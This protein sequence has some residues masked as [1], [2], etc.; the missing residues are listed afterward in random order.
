MDFYISDT[1]NQSLAKLNNDEQKLA[2]TT[3][4]DL[5]ANPA[6][7]GHSLHKLDNAKDK[8]FWSVRVGRDV[9]IIVHKS[10]SS[11]LLCYVDH[12]DKAYAWAQSRR[13]ETHPKTGAA[14]MV[15]IPEVVQASHEVAPKRTVRDS[16]AQDKTG[17]AT[18]PLDKVSD[19]VL[20][21]HGVPAD[22][23]APIRA[24]DEDGLLEICS[25]LPG[26]AAEALLQFAVGGKPRQL[27]LAL[28]VTTEV[29]SFAHPDAQRRFRLMNTPEALAL[30]LD[31]PW[32]RWVVFLHP[33]QRATVE[34][35]YAGPARVGG[36]AGTG[37]TIVALHRAVHLARKNPES[38]VLLTTFSTPLANALHDRLRRLVSSDRGLADRI[39]VLTLDALCDRLAKPLNAGT[40][41]SDATVKQLLT[42][43]A[44]GQ[45][46]KARPGFLFSEWS[47]VVDAWQ[48]VDWDSYRDARRLGRKT[49][50]NEERRGALWKVFAQVRE[51]LTAR[52][53]ITRAGLYTRLAADLAGRQ[54]PPYDHVVVDEAQDINPPQLRLLAAIGGA[55]ANGLFF[56]GDL[57]QRIFQQP[58]SWLSL[59]VDV[60]GRSRTLYV[61]YRTSHQIRAQA[62]RLLSPEVTD[63]DGNSDIRK[64]TTSVFNGPAPAIQMFAARAAEVDAVGEWLAE[65]MRGDVAPHEIGIFVR[66]DAEIAHARAAGEKAGL[67]IRML[68]ELSSPV[69]GSASISTMHLAKG[70]EFRAVV[71]MAC[72][73]D[74]IPSQARLAEVEDDAEMETLYET[75]RHLLYVAC[76]RARDHL[77]IT[78][79]SPGSEFLKDLEA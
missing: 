44:A 56:A 53:L 34:R 58:F 54:R 20:L 65:R 3:A 46:V 36:S 19:D 16:R 37:K 32:D 40:V 61:N 62:D 33:E 68:D 41:A 42:E 13:L 78:A 47:D 71:V 15:V 26:E 14:Q 35:D 24:A 59:G 9:R 28:P 27:P 10:A 11:M 74:V 45:G 64:G 43:V 72:D 75:E 55:R 18:R 7:P 70:L 67:K 60:R 79:L 1:F 5:Q 8:G 17:Q 4:F 57:G 52:K 6:T 31:A 76:T 23:L 25:Q 22:W 39:E 12:H 66:F 69:S 48:L 49:R 50:L 73:D 21:N 2:K 38:R 29:N 63:V 51:Q 77:L 30:A